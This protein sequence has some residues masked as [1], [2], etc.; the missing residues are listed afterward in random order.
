MLLTTAVCQANYSA[1]NY[2]FASPFVV[3][4]IPLGITF[5]IVWYLWEENYGDRKGSPLA[6]LQAAW[7]GV[8]GNMQIACLGAAQS[9]FEVRLSL[10]EWDGDLSQPAGCHVRLRV[11]LDACACHA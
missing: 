6:S 7:K 8:R 1:Q 4:L 3:S 5:F 10:E 2:G 9:C 11:Q